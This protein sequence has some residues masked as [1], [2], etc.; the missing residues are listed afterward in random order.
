M[1]ALGSDARLELLSQL[2]VFDSLSRSELTLLAERVSEESHPKGELIWHEGDPP[3]SFLLIVRGELEIWGGR[4]GKQVVN[5]LGPGDSLGEMAL[6]LD[7]R[8]TA[9]VTVSRRATVLALSKDEFLRVT[10]ANPKVLEYLLRVASR[11]L[12]ARTRGEL[13][14]RKSLVVGV[15]GKGAA[16]GKTMVASALSGLIASHLGDQVMT[17]QLE[18]GAT[19]RTSRDKSLSLSDAAESSE[20]ALLDRVGQRRASGPLL[21]VALPPD[22]DGSVHDAVGALIERL[23]DSFTVVIVDACADPRLE[24]AELAGHSDVLVELVA[25]NGDLVKPAGDAG[26]TRVFQVLNL[27]GTDAE[28]IPVNSG[29]PFVLPV[30]VALVDR[31]PDEVAR[32]VV[33]D[34]WSPASPPLHRLA[35]KILGVSVGIALGGGAAFGIAHVGVLRTLEEN[36]IPVD[37]TAGTSFGSIVALG[38][39]AGIRPDEME[40][41][42]TRIGNKRTTLSALDFTFTRPGLLAG[43][44]LKAIFSPALGATERFEHLALPCRTVATD[45]ESGERIAIGTGRLEDA[46][47]ASCSVPMLWAPVRRDG[48][49]LVDGAIVDPVPAAVAR[50]MGADLCIAV[51]VVPTVQKGVTTVLSRA[52][53]AINLLNAFSY[54]N[55]SRTMPN[56]FDV[57]MNSLQLLQYELGNY[58][59]LAGDVRL[60]VDLSRYTWIEF[61]R[62][63]EM[64]ERGAEAA[65][66]IVPELKQLLSDRLVVRAKEHTAGSRARDVA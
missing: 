27:R 56:I 63:A 7:E 11:R 46:F 57:G 40:A 20:A 61:Y 1:G 58:R 6:V 31:R 45:I 35:R 39:A 50:E 55:D 38:Y 48:R 30:D 26:G 24:P 28:A 59:A 3:D 60:N 37:L 51:N 23:T 10:A 32:Q 8:R 62:A 16:T 52:S 41:I 5:R 54:F 49:T 42:A 66:S 44:R 29:E 13:V 19:G 64:I 47:R 34:P 14:G 53:R 4:D 65:E 22:G 2:P 36:G 15:C 33:H 17:L 21:R 18:S 25:R 12:A 43:E 9:T